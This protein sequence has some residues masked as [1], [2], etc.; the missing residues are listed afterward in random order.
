MCLIVA[1][2]SPFLYSDVQRSVLF[3]ASHALEMSM[4]RILVS[5]LACS[6]YCAILIIASIVDIPALYSNWLFLVSM[7]VIL[8]SFQVISPAHILYM[9][10]VENMGL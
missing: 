1:M 8:V 7:C 6:M 2:W 5:R 3:I 9:I 4:G 10:Y